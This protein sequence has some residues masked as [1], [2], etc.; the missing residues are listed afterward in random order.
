MTQISTQNS[1]LT[2][3]GRTEDL[4]HLSVKLLL[5][6]RL[7]EEITCYSKLKG[8]YQGVKI[9]RALGPM[10]RKI[11]CG[12]SNLTLSGAQGPLILRQQ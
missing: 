12:P 11:A 8:Y 1:S 9:R 6:E 4:D 7:K 2:T 10:A 5:V 3:N